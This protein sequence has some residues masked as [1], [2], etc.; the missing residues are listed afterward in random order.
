[1]YLDMEQKK[2]ILQ[3]RQHLKCSFSVVNFALRPPHFPHAWYSSRWRSYRVSPLQSN[4]HKSVEGK[5]K[6]ECERSPPLLFLPP[7]FPTATPSL[8]I[9]PC[10]IHSSAH[11]QPDWSHFVCRIQDD[12]W[13]HHGTKKKNRPSLLLRDIVLRLFLLSPG[14]VS[15]SV[16]REEGM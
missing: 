7:T 4:S 13:C 16:V 10:H 3:F 8:H 12:H 15:C 2:Q 5:N 9:T 6:Q 14:S 11:A 1:M